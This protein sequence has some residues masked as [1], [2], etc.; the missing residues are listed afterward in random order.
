[1]SATA[2]AEI[3]APPAAED[4]PSPLALLFAPDR[5][6]ERHAKVGRA[7]WFFVFAWV[8]SILLGAALAYRVDAK[9]STLRKLEESGQLKTM[10]DRQVDDETR[11]A[12]RVSQVLSVAKGVTGAPVQLGTTCIAVLGLAW[13]LRGRIKGSA[14]APVAG[15]TLVPGAIANLLDAVAAFRHA[16]LPPE[17]VPL[18]P[19]S[20]TAILAVVGRPLGD[21][22]M[23]LGTALDFFSLWAA[24][25]LAFG[26]A[27][28]GQIPK[29]RALTGTLIAWVC[30]QLLTRVAV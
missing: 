11:S 2:E 30:Y 13:F 14:V 10:S 23:K 28:A 8:C 26:V 4:R 15:V 25:L 18:A 22:W 21:P 16:A 5:A 3:A 1:M 20:L 9:D 29:A 12:E 17:G 24:V 19:R 27:S 7:R 6:M